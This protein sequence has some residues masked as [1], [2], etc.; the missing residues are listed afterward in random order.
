M[1]DR[2]ATAKNAF[3][4]LIG[5]ANEAEGATR[6]SGRIMGIL[7]FEGR[8]MS[9]GELATALGVSRGSISTNTRSLVARGIIT[10]RNIDGERQ[11]YFEVSDTHSVTMLRDI[12]ARLAATAT[13]ISQ[14]AQTLPRDA[15]PQ[16]TRLQRFA[17]FHMTV[18]DAILTASTDVAAQKGED[19]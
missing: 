14:I 2:I 17:D 10:R 5:H 1:T 12:S 3:V 16:Q 9:F 7:I 19:P 11:D 6:I 18:S 4:D 13:K 8:A 15:A